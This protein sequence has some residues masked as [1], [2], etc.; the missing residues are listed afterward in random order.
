VKNV[1]RRFAQSS[2][3]HRGTP[4]APGRVVTVI[5]AKE[6]H[7]IARDVGR[8]ISIS[9]PNPSLGGPSLRWDSIG[10]GGPG[11][12]EVAGMEGLC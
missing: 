8:H 7:K 9:S 2:I 12:F 1:V 10:C 3:D 4:Q 11:G 6:W 5:D